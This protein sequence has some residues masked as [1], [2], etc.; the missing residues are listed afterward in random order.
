MV[1][2]ARG[3]AWVCLHPKCGEEGTGAAVV[4]QNPWV[5]G[6][7]FAAVGKKRTSC[8]GSFLCAHLS[9]GHSGELD[10]DSQVETVEVPRAGERGWCRL[11]RVWAGDGVQ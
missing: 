5:G 7:A 9:A 8:M 1:A 3:Q 4:S 2:R 10:L 6:G 11:G